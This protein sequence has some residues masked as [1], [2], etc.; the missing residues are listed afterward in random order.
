M[1]IARLTYGV[2]NGDRVKREY[3]YLVN[4]N[5]KVGDIVQPTVNH[6][7][8]GTLFATTGIIQKTNKPTSKEGRQLVEQL[9]QTGYT[10]DVAPELQAIVKDVNG[11]KMLVG[12]KRIGTGVGS[13]SYIAPQSGSKESRT[14]TY[15]STR[16]RSQQG[17]FA[18]DDYIGKA[19]KQPDGQ[20]GLS[21][22]KQYNTQNAYV[23]K[24]REYN[25]QMAQS[26]SG[27]AKFE[28]LGD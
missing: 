28:D 14:F 23:Q 11:V 27:S 5:V 20:Y 15:A 24:Q 21:Q 8:S 4:D 19:Q 3:A 18:K 25:K 1:K 17:T 26:E 2:H 6:A 22:D 7:K 16:E 13:M 10:R 12:L 9:G